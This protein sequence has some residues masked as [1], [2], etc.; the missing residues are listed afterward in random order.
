MALLLLVFLV[1]GTGSVALAARGA[2]PGQSLYPVKLAQERLRLALSF[3]QAGDARLH[4]EFAQERLVEVQELVLERRYDLLVETLARYEQEVARAVFLAQEVAEDDAAP[5]ARSQALALVNQMD[6][7]LTS[8]VVLLSVLS[9][10]VPQETAAEINQALELA[11]QGIFTLEVIKNQLIVPE[12][13]TTTPTPTSSPT[14][15]GTRVP[16]ETPLPTQ[17]S[18]SNASESPTATFEPA[19]V[20]TSL[21]GSTL[22]PTQVSQPNEPPTP[23]PTNTPKPTKVKPKPTNPNRPTARPTNPNRPTQKPDN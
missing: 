5:A 2:L 22:V 18:G 16:T 20:Q 3:T 6:E 14:S 8:Q 1:V 4:A 12:T 15:T 7:N 21:P 23:T 9:E 17:P 10:H 13:P 11:E 19:I